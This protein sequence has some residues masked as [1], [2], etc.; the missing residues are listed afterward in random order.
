MRGLLVVSILCGLACRSAPTDDAAAL[1]GA[2]AP[3]DAPPALPDGSIP[4]PAPV[5]PRCTAA[6]GF[7]PETVQDIVA[8]LNTLPKPVT[9]PCLLEAL[10]HPLSLQ[11]VNSILSAQPAV[12]RRSPRFFI[13][14]DDLTL[15]VVPAG[16]G[17]QLLE[18]GERRSEMHTLKAELEF[19]IETQL[20]AHSPYTRLRFDDQH[21]S[22]GFCHAEEDPVEDIDHA[23]ARI[24]R[25][26]RPMPSQRIGMAE[27][28]AELATC[29]AA[30]EPARCAMLRA[31][32]GPKG[33]ALDGEFPPEWKTFF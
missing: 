7:W 25:A 9:L 14:F 13:F 18:F 10:P 12:G 30:A 1:P 2:P 27:L 26:I 4:A 5:D 6:P 28:Q 22:C 20:D 17:A 32:F 24:S 8:L 15:S 16:E 11:A 21:T 29:D 31:L 3:P 19:P 33:T 23:Y